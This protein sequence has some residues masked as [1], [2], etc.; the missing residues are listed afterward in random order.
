MIKSRINLF[1]VS[2]L[3]TTLFISSCKLHSELPTIIAEEIPVPI[4]ESSSIQIPV[5][6]NLQPIINFANS[7]TDK[8]IRNPDYPNFSSFEGVEGPRA[9]YD[10][11]IGSLTGSMQGNIFNVGTTAAYGIAGD[12]C[13]EIVWGKCIHP[14]IPF[15]CGTNNEAKRKVKIG[16]SSKVEIT[17]DYGL[18]TQTVVSEVTPIDP[19]KMTF[20]K[21][22]MTNKVMDAMRPSLNDCAKFIDQQSKSTSFKAIA[23]DAW[24]EL[25]T[26][27]EI[28]GYGFLCINPNEISVSELKG[29]GQTLNF[30]IGLKAN[31]KFTLTKDSTLKTPALPA[32]KTNAKSNSEFVFNMPIISSYSELTNTLS[33]NLNEKT[34]QSDDGKQ[35]ILI[36]QI[37]ISGK[38]NSTILLEMNCDLKMGIKKFKNATLYFTM[39]PLFD[40]KT[41]TLELSNVKLA[42]DKKHVLLQAGTELFQ[43]TIAQKIQQFG[44]TDLKPILESNKKSISDQLHKQ[45]PN[46]AQLN[47]QVNQLKILGIY[48]T[49]NNLIIHTQAIGNLNLKMSDYSF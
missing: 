49:E 25:W 19:C 1:V 32:L 38:G 35:T 43:K 10:V 8:V 27:I 4:L 22:D 34:F 23:K 9:S 29:T 16:F 31:P 26:P 17:S 44:K 5:E 42:S 7:K 39:K 20:L 45:L 46:N 28:E 40:N 13:S 36:H 33:K 6:V 2:L 14:R 15:S 12:Y 24:K 37:T 41:Q 11:L 21:I 18:K 48:P 30:N 3:T 47:G